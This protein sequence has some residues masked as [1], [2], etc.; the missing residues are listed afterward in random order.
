MCL[1]KGYDPC[2]FCLARS[3]LQ[4]NPK[5]RPIQ[6]EAYIKIFKNTIR[7]NKVLK[8]HKQVINVCSMS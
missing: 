5:F 4:G 7:H 6:F 2:T 1:T 3:S 8:N